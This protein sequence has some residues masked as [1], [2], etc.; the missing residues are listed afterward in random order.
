MMIVENNYDLKTD[1]HILYY[2]RKPSV[3]A[4]KMFH[5]RGIRTVGDMIGHTKSQLLSSPNCW[6]KTVKEI[7]D[8]LAIVGL[9]LRRDRET[10][11][12]QMYQEAPSNL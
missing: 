5:Y 8:V 1:I 11:V 6:R 3:R 7:E 10:R 2:G 12:S 4:E 9:T